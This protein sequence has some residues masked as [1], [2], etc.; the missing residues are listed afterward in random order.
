MPEAD[1]DHRLPELVQGADVFFQTLNPRFR[2]VN[3]PGAS[4]DE[5]AVAVIG[6]VRKLPGEHVVAHTGQLLGMRLQKLVKHEIVGNV[7][8]PQVLRNVVTFKNA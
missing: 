7:P 3:T 1:A 8:G 2:L 6:M 4:R 5:V